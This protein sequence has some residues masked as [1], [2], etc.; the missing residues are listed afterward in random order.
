MDNTCASNCVAAGTPA[1]QSAVNALVN[2]LF[3][4]SGACPGTGGVCDSTAAGYN[5]TNCGNCLMTAQSPT[6]ACSSQVATC[7]AN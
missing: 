2:C 5:A 4:T 7:Q 1:A 3:G 6:G